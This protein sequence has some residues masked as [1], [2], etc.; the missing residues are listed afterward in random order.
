MVNLQS[1]PITNTLAVRASLLH[2]GNIVATLDPDEAKVLTLVFE[3][4]MLVNPPHPP[5]VRT[6]NP[7]VPVA[8]VPGNV[9]YLQAGGG[10]VVLHYVLPNSPEHTVQFS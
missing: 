8:V 4:V 5:V 6:Q 7:A 2:N 10:G 3:Q 9:A 1:T